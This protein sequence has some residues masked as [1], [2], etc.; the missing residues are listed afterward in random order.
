M[1]RLNEVAARLSETRFA[2]TRLALPALLAVAI[3]TGP[4]QAAEPEKGSPL[5]LLRA[6]DEGFTQLFE[7]IAPSVVVI[8]A[9]KKTDAEDRE[10][11]KSFE[12]FLKENEEERGKAAGEASRSMRLPAP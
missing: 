4:M 12:S 6:I 9:V 7:K 11:L 3:G 5:S 8:E 2:M 1:S 10:E